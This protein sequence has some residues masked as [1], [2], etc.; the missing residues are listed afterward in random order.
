MTALGAAKT[1]EFTTNE[2]FAELFESSVQQGEYQEGSIIHG[3][4]VTVDNSDVL[5]DVGLKSEGCI[6][7]KEFGAD[8]T[9]LKAGDTVEVYFER[10]ENRNGE[11]VLSRERA[12]RE[13]AWEVL[14]RQHDNAERV[15]GTIF[16]KVKGGFTV[17]LNGAIA[18]LPG[19][20]VDVRPVRDV[21]PLMG[22]PQPFQILKMDRKRGNIVVSRRAILEESRMEAKNELLDSIK[23]GQELEGVVKN[24]TNYGAFIDLGGMDG[25]L[26]V[27]DMS[28][29][30]VNHP[31]EL[32][33][34]GDTINVVV[35]KFNTE[36]KR[37]SLG[38]KQLENNPWQGIEDR[39][40]IG[41]KVKGKVTNITDLWCVC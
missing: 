26:H 8:A 35:T 30:R 34:V 21:D 27:T 32:L 4:V 6:P 24:I 5:V 31:S 23:E 12:L 16:G 29:K 25:L 15:E 1:E 38:M 10:Y 22:I 36:T 9:E 40:P 19:S 20:Q 37:I 39:Y 28:W 7:L 18:F 41:A 14:E 3:L 33:N 11:L 2:N 13:K 17:D